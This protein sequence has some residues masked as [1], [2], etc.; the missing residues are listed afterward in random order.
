[1]GFS[2]IGLLPE[3]HRRENP[4]CWCI[5]AHFF[6]TGE[7]RQN[8]EEDITLKNDTWRSVVETLKIISGKLHDLNNLESGVVCYTDLAL[9]AVEAVLNKNKGIFAKCA[10]IHS[11]ND[12]SQSHHLSRPVQSGQPVW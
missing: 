12:R 10:V 7:P 3:Y 11:P 5:P 4:T 2:S 8:I 1:M 9:I 6:Q